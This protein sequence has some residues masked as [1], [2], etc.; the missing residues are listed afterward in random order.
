[1]E[2]APTPQELAE[3]ALRALKGAP[4]SPHEHFEF[5]VRQGIIDRSGRVL[6]A[7]LFGEAAAPVATSPEPG[8]PDPAKNG[9]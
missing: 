8:S 5:L 7:R 6:V 4:M 3:E 2:K 9:A 1:M